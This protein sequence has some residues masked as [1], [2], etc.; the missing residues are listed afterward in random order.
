MSSKNIDIEFMRL[1]DLSNIY[2]MFSGLDENNPP[3]R[4]TKWKFSRKEIIEINKA[5]SSDFRNSKDAKVGN[6]GG[7]KVGNDGRC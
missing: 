6:D 4:N 5:I 1:C 7:A 3:L 2:W